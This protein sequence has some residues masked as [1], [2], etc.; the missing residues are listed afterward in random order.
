MLC[1]I[2]SPVCS[3]MT[4]VYRIVASVAQRLAL[5][6]RLRVVIIA[7]PHSVLQKASNATHDGEPD[8]P[9]DADDGTDGAEE[10]MR[11]HI[12]AVHSDVML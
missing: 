3:L 1:F 6:W 8:G 10:C 5:R 2:P 12:D 9:H 7:D 4:Y 11:M